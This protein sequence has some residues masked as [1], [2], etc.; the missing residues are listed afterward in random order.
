M[1]QQWHTIRADDTWFVEATDF[2]EMQVSD[3]TEKPPVATR[4]SELSGA[5]G[6]AAG[7][8]AAVGLAATLTVAG[9]GS[10]L[11]SRRRGAAAGR[12]AVRAGGAALV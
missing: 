2:E 3:M 11:L 8:M 4:A 10:A 7:A 6:A 12:V 1:R 9:I 5:A